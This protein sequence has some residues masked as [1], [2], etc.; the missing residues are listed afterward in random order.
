M[1][2][3]DRH[4]LSSLTFFIHLLL[5]VFCTLLLTVCFSS[6][7][8]SYHFL[9][10]LGTQIPANVLNCATD[11]KHPTLYWHMASPTTGQHLFLNNHCVLGHLLE[12]SSLR[13]HCVFYS[14]IIYKEGHLVKA[15]C[16]ILAIVETLRPTSIFCVLPK[17]HL[18]RRS[19]LESL[20]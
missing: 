11:V 9:S 3:R 18:Q 12:M 5:R 14:R 20:V 19:S 10:M 15:F 1:C 7:A 17:D 2:I 4:Q 8:V 16:L 13:Q 6:E